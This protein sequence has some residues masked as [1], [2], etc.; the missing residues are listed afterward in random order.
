MEVV[1]VSRHDCSGWLEEE[2]MGTLR[3]HLL[4]ELNE[5]GGA[6]RFAAYYPVSG[7]SSVDVHS[8]LMVIDDRILRVGSAN[9]ANRSM[10]L[11]TECDLVVDAADSA[12]ARRGI[13]RVRAR[14]LS[15]HLGTD[16]DRVL[17]SIEERGSLRAAIEALRGGPKTLDTLPIDVPEEGWMSPGPDLYR[18]ADPE[19]PIE[20]ELIRS[21]VS[22]RKVG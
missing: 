22:A 15:D 19:K 1:L 18:I 11:D 12:A 10:G 5:A 2:V 7:E 21:N 13:A 3:A 17:R 14:L 20:G 9:L 8:K 6:S 16:T 4:C